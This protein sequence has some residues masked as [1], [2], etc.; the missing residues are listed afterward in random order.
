MISPDASLVHVPNP[1]QT[2]GHSGEAP[3][4]Q[5]GMVLDD[6]YES[7]GNSEL[8]LLEIPLV[9]GQGSEEC[10]LGVED[11]T[12]SSSPIDVNWIRDI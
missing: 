1:Q 4:S 6:K 9:N 2:K 7:L 11:S 12:S 10:G 5:N 3:D 8:I